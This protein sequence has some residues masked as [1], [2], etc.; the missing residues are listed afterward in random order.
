MA[1]MNQSTKGHACM[2]CRYDSVPATCLLVGGSTLSELLQ[3]RVGQ[4]GE[5]T[6]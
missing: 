2:L 4:G 6:I 3:Q 5:G 1:D